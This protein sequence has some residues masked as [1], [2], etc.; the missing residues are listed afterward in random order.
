MSKQLIL[1][2]L[3]LMGLTSCAPNG[4]LT[5]EPVTP[6]ASTSDSTQT[7]SFTET[8]TF[9]VTA[10]PTQNAT[11]LGIDPDDLQGV[12]IQFWHPWTQDVAAAADLLVDQ[13]NADNTY[14]IM[15]VAASHDSDLYQDVRAGINSGRMPNVTLGLSHQIQSWTHFRDIV[16]DLSPYVGDRIWGL[17]E[18]EI[19]DFHPEIWGQ[20][21]FNEV[22]LGLPVY[23]SA[24]VLF[25]NRSWAR[26]LG[27]RAPP[28][29]PDEFKEQACAAAAA[30]AVNTEN[31]GGWI[32]SIDPS[33]I[34]SWVLAFGGDGVNAAG[35]G[36]AFNTPEVLAAFEFIKGLF[37]S[38]CAWYPEDRY[39]NDKFATRKGLF[40]SSSISGIPYQEIAFES[41]EYLDEWVPIPYPSETSSPV[42]DLY[43]P[44]YAI[45]E[46]TPEEQLAAWLFIKWMT[47]PENQALII[48]ASGYFPSR[49][50]VTGLLSGYAGEHPQWA[51]ALDLIP[52]SLV[53]PGF[54]SWGIGRW[55]LQD[56]SAE[57]ILPGFTSQ[58]IP[59]LLEE[60][61]AILAE[62]HAQNQ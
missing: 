8:P 7:P 33:T 1:L 6:D 23:R 22:R 54:G 53:E 34:M 50:S 55:T 19:S 43:G 61:A 2:V 48:E 9:Q 5:S 27:F 44:A 16:L 26:E 11:S 47:L 31:A 35:D 29:S 56:A 20:D 59:L 42:I 18:T 40:L 58:E 28:V 4:V 37:K 21:V 51:A 12:T 62:I 10:E 13:F 38:G 15:V 14:G 3:I 52:F 32:A 36:Y 17:S 30:S 46:S 49:I 57:L 41:N 39:P 45:L 60:L 25:Y 24:T